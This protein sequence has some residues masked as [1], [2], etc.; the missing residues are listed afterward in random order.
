[1]GRA[2]FKYCERNVVDSRYKKLAEK[3]AGKWTESPGAA[4]Q[5]QPEAAPKG[6]PGPGQLSQP[7]PPDGNTLNK[8]VS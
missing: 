1:M 5:T 6:T 3:E 2:D 4:V 8:L 7:A